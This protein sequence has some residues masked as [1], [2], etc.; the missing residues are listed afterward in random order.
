M[1]DHTLLSSTALVVAPAP[2][3]PRQSVR[4]AWRLI[5]RSRYLILACLML[6]VVPAILFLQQVTPRYTS[7]ALIM[8]Q[9]PDT[10]DVLTDRT[11]GMSR[12]LLNESVMTT[13]ADLIG[14]GTIARRVVAK[15]HLDEDPEFNKKLAKPKALDVFLTSINPLTWIPLPGGNGDLTKSLSPAAQEDVARDKVVNTVL[16]NL[17]VTFQRRSYIISVQFT[18]EDPEKAARIANSFAEMYV[19]DRLEASFEEAHRISDWLGERLQTLQ[20]DV[21]TAE[22]AV[23]LFRSE[24]GLRQTGVRQTTIGEQ[25]LSELNS[26]LV[27]ARSDLAEK[28]ARLGQI[29]SLVRSHGNVETSSDVLQSTLI[30]RLREQESAKSSELS[31]AMKTY[32]DRHPK[33]VGLRADLADLRSKISD[34]IQKIATSVANDVEVASAGVN[35]LQHELDQLR[36]QDNTNNEVGVRLHELERQAEAN[37]TLYETFLARF[38]NEAE[39]GHMRRANAR[40]VSVASIPIAPSYPR[41]LVTLFLVTVFSLGLGL[42]IVFLLDRIDNAVRSADEAEALTGL[43]MLAMVPSHASDSSRPIDAL[44]SQPRSA[45][46]DGVRSLRTALLTAS[47]TDPNQII[48]VTSSEPKEGKTFVSLC[49]AL[50]VSKAEDRVLLIDSDVYRPRLHSALNLS[51]ER[52]LAQVLVGELRFE[53]VVQRGIGGSLDFLPA[54]RHANLTEVLQGPRIEA[55]F[56]ELRTRYTRIVV[57]SPPVL[58]V[59]E[60][61]TLARLADRVIYLIKWSATARDAVRNGIKLL[62]AAGGNLF[63][64]V[65]S[66][67][68]QRKHSRY[69]YR[70]Y[71]HYY[72][73]YREYYGE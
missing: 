29:R 62:R 60:V 45:L 63:G 51:G 72:G 66:Q 40:V 68:N 16:H 4:W 37:K 5:W 13:E 55:L 26:R 69:G 21:A 47:D 20:K 56:A 39:Q 38:K 30:Q 10:N 6:G 11:V 23:E 36:H 44:L 70:D 7:A 61:R 12:A 24:H 49:L 50:M 22:N 27:I 14:S 54:G 9:A 32:G 65:L 25:Q 67:V 52:G 53:D 43:P 1:T 57:D 33:I 46:A 35:S 18:S 73:R 19:L 59:S 34:E 42:A 15:L 17:K 28:Q 71:G 58:A 3:D 64:V 31:D 2:P 41:K 48:L 8:I